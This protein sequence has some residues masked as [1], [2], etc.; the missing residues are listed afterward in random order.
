MKDYLYFSIFE[1]SPSKF[2][3]VNAIENKHIPAAF[4]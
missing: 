1:D 4:A 2:A 3:P